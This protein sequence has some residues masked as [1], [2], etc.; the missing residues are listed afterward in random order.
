MKRSTKVKVTFA[1]VEG[2]HCQG[3]SIS[4][5]SRELQISRKDVVQMLYVEPVKTGTSRA[6]TLRIK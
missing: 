6:H 5:I 2:L 3:Y 4:E 1:D